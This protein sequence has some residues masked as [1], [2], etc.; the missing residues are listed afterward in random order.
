[1]HGRPV[2]C[3]DIGGMAEKVRHGIDGLHFNV[4]NPPHL[5]E[6]VRTAVST[7]GLWDRLRDGIPSVYGMEEHVTRLTRIYAD[8]IARRAAPTGRAVAPAR[9]VA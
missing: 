7:P 8:L 9:T 2:I 6:T 1:M 5:A 3:S 4:N